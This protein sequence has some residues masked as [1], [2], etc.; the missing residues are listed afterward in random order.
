MDLRR[1][2]FKPSLTVSPDRFT[3]MLASHHILFGLQ[4]VDCLAGMPGHTGWPVCCTAKLHA[5]GLEVWNLGP[6]SRKPMLLLR[7]ITPLAKSLPS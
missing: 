3:Q 1:A 7:Y 4:P 2:T 5:V 6:G